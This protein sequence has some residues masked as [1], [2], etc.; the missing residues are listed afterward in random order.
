MGIHL[1][2]QEE[3]IRRRVKPRKRAEIRRAAQKASDK[4]WYALH[5][6]S[7]RPEEEQCVAKQIEEKYSDDELCLCDRCAVHNEAT[8]SA[9]R[10][11][12]GEEWNFLQE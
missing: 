9:L 8:L 2:A 6:A 5:V 1:V 12:L 10:W 3:E 4:V 11:V 7:G